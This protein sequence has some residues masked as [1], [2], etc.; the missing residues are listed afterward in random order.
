MIAVFLAFLSVSSPVIETDSGLVRGASSGTVWSFKNIPYAAPPVGDLRWRPPQAVSPWE[1]ERDATEWGGACTQV[2][3]SGKVTGSED[4]LQ[5]NVFT[6]AGAP[7]PS[8]PVLFWIHGGSLT[9]GSAVSTS[10]GVRQFDGSK[11]AEKTGVVLVSINYRLGPLGYLAHRTLSWEQP[12][13]TTGNYGMLDQIAALEWVHRNIARFGGDPQRVAIFGQSAGATSVCALVAS[14]RAAGLFSGAIMMSG[15]CGARTLASSQAQGDAIFAYAGCSEDADPAACMRGVS[16]ERVVQIPRSPDFVSPVSGYSASIDGYLLTDT[17]ENL[18]GRG[19]HN[20]LPVM[21]GNTS[22][23][24][25]NSA[26][27]IASEFEYRQAIRALVPYTGADTL[28]MNQYPVS[29]YSSYR[30]AYVALLSDFSYVWPARRAAR[31]FLAGQTE[32]VWR[33][34][35]S[36]IPDNAAPEVRAQGA[37]HGADTPYVFDTLDRANYTSSEGELELIDLIQRFW[38]RMAEAGTPGGDDLPFWPRYNGLDPYLRLET[39]LSLESG[40]R[41]RQCDFWDYMLS[42]KP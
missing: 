14:P 23:E 31:A 19:R 33:Y 37:V 30:D 2:D 29:E 7:E 27:G 39:P 20:H 35:F 6:P 32:P 9:S 24:E 28:I 11:L 26:T 41:A 12:T 22:N 21:I 16:A 1:G 40:F 8:R 15:S 10:G 3:S 5:L 18:V 42:I 4:C 13:G 38:S 17:P 34:V 25:G 36:H